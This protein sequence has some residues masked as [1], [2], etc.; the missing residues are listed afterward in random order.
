MSGSGP[1]ATLAS[2]PPQAGGQ[3]QASA[4]PEFSPPAQVGPVAASSFG[5]IP[6]VAINGPIHQY[7]GKRLA[8]IVMAALTE[9]GATIDLPE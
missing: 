1:E 8:A 3:A 4:V 2:S 7:S 5:G 9:V 6:L